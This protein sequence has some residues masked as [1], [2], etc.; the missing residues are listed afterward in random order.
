MT[1]DTE[2]SSRSAQGLGMNN[3]LAIGASII[4][5]IGIVLMVVDGLPEFRGRRADDVSQPKRLA[6]AIT[7]SSRANWR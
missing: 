3:T 2:A 5:L 4:N 7:K 1:M 6:S